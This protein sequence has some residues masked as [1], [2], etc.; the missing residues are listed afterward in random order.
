M[1]LRGDREGGEASGVVKAVE[2]YENAVLPEL[3]VVQLLSV[4]S[5]L[6]ELGR[7]RLVAE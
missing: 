6:L 3:S 4:V 2:A 7:G 1:L 5:L